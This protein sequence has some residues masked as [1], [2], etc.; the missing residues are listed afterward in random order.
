MRPHCVTALIF[1]H[2]VQAA[3]MLAS[4]HQ[5]CDHR[6]MSVHIESTPVDAP[7]PRRSAGWWRRNGWWLAPELLAV[8][9]LAGSIVTGLGGQR[10]PD[11]LADEVA[12]ILEQI[13][14]AEHHNH[15]HQVT[16]QDTVLCVAEVFGA[17]PADAASL[18]EV[19]DVYAYYMCAAG[20][21]GTPY[22]RSQ[23][24]SGP[25]AVTLTNPPTARIA[26]AGAG[27]QDRVR[28]IIPER[29]LDR[30]FGVFVDSARPISLRAR[31]ESE[32]ANG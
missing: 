13:P 27:Y 7:P 10:L 26:Q 17:E 14:P 30:A 16:E 2:A 19:T 24:I 11:Q 15:G 5:W 18:S 12:R 22:E 6:A 3:A 4:C 32:V 28:A 25:V 21:P 8:A 1:H 20:T 9:L 29:H 23:R 31:Y